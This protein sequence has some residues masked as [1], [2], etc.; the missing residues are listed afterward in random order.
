MQLAPLH[1][2]IGSPDSE[3]LMTATEER[4]A[5]AEEAAA[6][7]GAAPVQLPLPLPLPLQRAASELQLRTEQ[8]APSPD[9]ASLQDEPL[10]DDSP[11]T[12][13]PP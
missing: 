1:V 2:G 12:P 6:G 9:A 13:R 4:G 11:G 10:M 7:P 3:V 8:G 5:R